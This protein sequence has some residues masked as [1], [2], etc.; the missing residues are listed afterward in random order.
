VRFEVG[1]YYRHSGGG[2]M[3]ILVTAQTEMYGDCLIAE[4]HS[5]WCLLPVGTD[6]CNAEHWKEITEEEWQCLDNIRTGYAVTASEDGTEP[7]LQLK[8]E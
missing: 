3:H 4:E 8:G 7:Q 2:A 5:S 6:E 1:K